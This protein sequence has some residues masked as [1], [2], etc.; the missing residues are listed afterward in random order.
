[1]TLFLLDGR[2]V[3]RATVHWRGCWKHPRAQQKA[4]FLLLL[5]ATLGSLTLFQAYGRTELRT[6]SQQAAQYSAEQAGSFE[7]NALALMREW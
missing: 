6:L 7:T 3:M 4:A 1:M 5:S 2:L